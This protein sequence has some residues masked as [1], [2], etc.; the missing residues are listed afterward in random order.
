MQVMP[1][2]QG[3]ASGRVLSA[4]ATLV[5]GAGLVLY[6]LTSLVLGPVANRQLDFSLTIPAVE[7]QDL[8]EPPAPASTV[9]VGTH[10]TPAAHAALVPT[11]RRAVFVAT[12][13]PSSQPRPAVIASPASHSDGKKHHRDH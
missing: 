4:G 12:P 8:S 3:V 11:P 6:Q 7:V 10:V 2:V 1:G 9:V 5:I 13:R